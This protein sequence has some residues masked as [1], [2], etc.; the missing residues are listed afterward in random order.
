MRAGGHF[1]NKTL[2]LTVAYELPD[3]SIADEDR[4][5]SKRL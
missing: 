3:S 1:L 5:S 4:N 2:L